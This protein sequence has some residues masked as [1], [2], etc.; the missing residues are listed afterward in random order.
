MCRYF[1]IPKRSFFFFLDFLFFALHLKD[2][3]WKYSQFF[4]CFQRL[5]VLLQNYTFLPYILSQGSPEQTLLIYLSYIS[6]ADSEFWWHF[7]DQEKL[8]F[9]RTI[10]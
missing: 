5:L 2:V 8:K 7:H 6:L 10:L 9:K 1:K 3:M 4:Q